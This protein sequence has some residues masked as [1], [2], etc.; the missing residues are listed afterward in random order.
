MKKQGEHISDRD[1]E[2]LER[3]RDRRATY[4]LA[5]ATAIGPSF[6]V[7]LQFVLNAI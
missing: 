3:K 1:R 4:A 7:V 2:L 5:I 6:A